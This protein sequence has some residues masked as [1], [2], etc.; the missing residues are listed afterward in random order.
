MP[1]P[2]TVG[3]QVGGHSNAGRGPSGRNP[4]GEFIPPAD[5][6]RVKAEADALRV[7]A[8]ERAAR[9]AQEE[10][11]AAGRAFAEANKPAKSKS[12][13]KEDA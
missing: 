9:E 13:K 11:L 7:K 3:R 8:K 6:A 12:K 1:L 10:L 2:Q 4:G 5:K